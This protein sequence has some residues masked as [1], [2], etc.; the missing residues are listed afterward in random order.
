MNPKISVLITVYNGERFLRETIESVLNQTFRNFELIIVNDGST[1]NTE[2][3]IQKFI[4]KD[5][6][7]VYL[8]NEI[9]K[10]YYNWH[11]ILNMGL[12]IAKGK[13]IARLDAD[14][15]CYLNRLEV[16]YAYLE[17]H[18]N[19]FLIGSSVDVID[20]Y[21]NNIDEIIKKPWSSFLL[22]CKIAFSN[23]YIHSSLMFR[24]EGFKYLYHNEHFFYFN[25]LIYGKKL[26]NITKKLVKYRIN[27]DGLMSQYADLSKNK[28]IK[29]YK[30]KKK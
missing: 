21:G 22:K 24:N 12:K 8:K 5:N 11:N 28:Y 30:P 1:D 2:K 14:D 13:Y 19:I 23:S 16:Q 4:S 17:K 20:E 29:F 10:G 9:N 6:R 27:P 7:I 18:K 15:I 3:I 25:L 26:K